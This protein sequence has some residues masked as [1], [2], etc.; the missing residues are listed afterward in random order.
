M[1]ILKEEQQDFI[2]CTSCTKQCTD[3]ENMESDSDSNWFCPECW[4]DLAPRMRAEWQEMKRNGEIDE[5]D[6][7]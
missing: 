3:I 7:E 5:D 4:E 1:E 2:T 6:T